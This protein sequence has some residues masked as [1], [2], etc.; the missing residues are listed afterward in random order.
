MN[1]ALWLTTGTPGIVV[2]MERDW[3]SEGLYL[4]LLALF[5]PTGGLGLPSLAVCIYSVFFIILVN[6]YILF[7]DG[8]V[9]RV[10]T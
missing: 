5:F 9:G 10:L 2:T 8:A 6:A 1:Q 3:D 4:F 7:Q